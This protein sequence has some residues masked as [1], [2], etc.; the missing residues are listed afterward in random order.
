MQGLEAAYLDAKAGTG[1]ATADAAQVSADGFELLR[2]LK[3]A[4]TCHVAVLKSNR[5]TLR[6][7]GTYPGAV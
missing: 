1:G 5:N 3:G 6:G 7:L 4:K 2:L